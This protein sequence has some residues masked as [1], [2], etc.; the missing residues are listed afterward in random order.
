MLGSGVRCF[1]PRPH[2][3]RAPFAAQSFGAFHVCMEAGL[4]LLVVAEH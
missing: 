3:L 2:L 4:G 1:V